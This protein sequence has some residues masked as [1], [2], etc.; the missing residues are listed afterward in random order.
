V[1]NPLL[2][3]VTVY[4]NKGTVG[5]VYATVTVLALAAMWA[6]TVSKLTTTGATKISPDMPP[7]GL[8]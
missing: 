8:E 1:A 6:L 7:L 4:K 5:M 3:L 2:V